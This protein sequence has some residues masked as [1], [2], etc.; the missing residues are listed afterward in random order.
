M[1]PRILT[2]VVPIVAIGANLIPNKKKPVSTSIAVSGSTDD[3][4][5]RLPPS[6][7]S[8]VQGLSLRAQE[9][10]TPRSTGT[11]T[12]STKIAEAPSPIS[13][14]P[15]SPSPISSGQCAA[16]HTQFTKRYAIVVGNDKYADET[17]L[18]TCANDATD[19]GEKLR[20]MGFEVTVLTNASVQEIMMAV[21]S[22]GCKRVQGDLCVFYYSGYGFER[23]QQN[24]IL[25]SGPDKQKSQQCNTLRLGHVLESLALLDMKDSDSATVVILDACRG[26]ASPLFSKRY[27]TPISTKIAVPENSSS[28]YFVMFASDS[29]RSAY[30]PDGRN[31]LFTASLLK[32]VA[33]KKDINHVFRDVCSDLFK[34]T[35]NAGAIQRPWAHHCLRRELCLAARD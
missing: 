24:Y 34:A 18:R 2:F 30:T 29:T 23:S 17:E 9:P 19:V 8:A 15:I 5:T 12:P 32:H 22:F 13:P 27:G 6:L 14:S 31:S 21:S 20:E 10:C 1:L 25:G 16:R 33:M 28:Q 4:S 7:I 35:E 3:K 26:Q 11:G